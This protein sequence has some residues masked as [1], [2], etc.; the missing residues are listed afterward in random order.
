MVSP[1]Y[2]SMNSK[3]PKF[4]ALQFNEYINTQDITGLSSLMTEDHTL[5]LRDGEVV[6][7][8]APNTKGW[9]EFFATFPDYKNNFHSVQSRDNLVILL[10]Y[11]YWSDKNPYD[12]AIW[13]AMIENNL[14]AEWRIYP[15]SDETR[16]KLNI[17]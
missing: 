1:F 5:I 10:G 16:S 15:E 11:A 17:Q 4:I 8:K 3:D 13:T 14:V 12:P 6:K 9:T 2:T 7:G